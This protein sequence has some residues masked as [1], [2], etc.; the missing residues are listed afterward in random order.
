MILLDTHALIWWFEGSPKLSLAAKAA[1]E[2]AQRLSR[3]TISSLSCWEIA[4]LNAH[5]RI[6]LSTELHN[7]IK[8][9]QKLRRVRFIPVD[10]HIAVASVELPGQ[11]HKDPADRIIVATAITMNIPVVTVDHKIRAYPHVRT[12]W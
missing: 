7:W 8:A 10:N 5:G 11:F 12:I 9:I 3:V 6:H 1:I 2:N 4:L